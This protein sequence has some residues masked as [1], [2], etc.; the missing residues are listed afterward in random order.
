MCCDL[1]GLLQFVVI[2]GSVGEVLCFTFRK[3]WILIF[4][5]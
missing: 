4:V 2:F 5:W 3:L 1:L